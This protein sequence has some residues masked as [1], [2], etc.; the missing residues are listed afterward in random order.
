LDKIKKITELATHDALTNLP[1]RMGFLNGLKSMMAHA[2][3]NNKSVALMFID[4]DKFKYVND[5]YGHQV[6]DELLIEVASRMKK[7]VRTEDII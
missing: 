4:L 7:C 6:G 5:T 3:R 2:N 1:N